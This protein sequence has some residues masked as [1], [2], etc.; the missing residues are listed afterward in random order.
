MILEPVA[1]YVARGAFPQLAREGCQC[2]AQVVGQ[3]AGGVEAERAVL[4]QPDPGGPRR[5][6]R[7]RASYASSSK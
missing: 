7:A 6:R 1:T 4:A 2:A 3:P 5:M